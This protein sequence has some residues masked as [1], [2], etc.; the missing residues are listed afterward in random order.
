MSLE[1]GYANERKVI[2]FP[3][4]AKKIE[5][6]TRSIESPDI[7]PIE[8]EMRAKLSKLKDCRYP[9]AFDW[10]VYD[11]I[12]KNFDTPPRGGVVF[13]TT[14]KLVNY[15][16]SCSKCHYAFELDTYGRGCFHNCVYC[17]AKDQ[18]T[19]YR[20]WNEPQ[21][22]PVNLAEIRKIFYTVFETDKHSKWREIMEKRIPL[23][24]GSMSDSFMW[25]DVKYGVTAE[26]LKILSFYKYPYIVFTRS[27]LVAHD[28][29]LKLID[30]DLA[31]IQFSI[32]GNNNK[33][34]RLMEPGAPSYQRRLKAITKLTDAGVWT[35]VRI[36]PLFPKYPDGYFSDHEYVK[37][38][39]GSR[40]SV[41]VFD[42]Y[43]DQFL[44]ELHEAGAKSVLTGFVRLS[45]NAT[46]SLQRT[47]G[48]DLKPFFKKELYAKGG[49]GESRFSDREI[50]YYYRWFG[51]MAREAGIRFTTCYIGMGLKD[52]F[53]YQDLWTNKNDCCDVVGNVASFSRT[54]QSIGWEV[55][56]AHA[57]SKEI[58]D[59]ARREELTYEGSYIS[60]EVTHIDYAA[61]SSPASKSLGVDPNVPTRL[62]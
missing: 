20:Y 33:L 48:V 41:P 16:S 5:A 21:P 22:F 24:L 12:A 56:R 17:Y 59:T 50:A 46:N 29:Y 61:G 54:A 4:I 3:A 42:L 31:A 40:S 11:K 47:T 62:S 13:N 27:D 44:P 53:Q 7:G 10:S 38:K 57:P 49:N 58:A 1:F 43:N 45:G 28:E 14:M 52:F 51:K 26:M 23:R 9:D 2:P 36:N 8:A 37:E 39:F 6:D 18:L 34:A 55:R 25:L 15:H 32:S 60:S 30:K 35:S 19:T